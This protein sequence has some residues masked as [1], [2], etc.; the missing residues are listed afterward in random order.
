MPA[1][2][3]EFTDDEAAQVLAEGRG[4]AAAMLDLAWTLE[5]KLPGTRAAFAGG[6]L[7]HS[8]AQVIAL[9][10]AFL[11]AAEARAAEAEVL[12]RAGRLTPGGLRA[13]IARAVMAVAP[14]KA[15]KRREAAARDAR[16]AAVGRGLRERR[17]GRAGTPPGAGAGRR[18]AD[19]L[20]GPAA[21]ES[22]AGRGHGPAAR[23][24]LPRPAARPGL[25]PRRPGRDAARRAGWTAAAAPAAAARDRRQ[26]G[27]RQQDGYRRQPGT[28]AG[29]AGIPAGAPAPAPPGAGTRP[30][31]FAGRLHLTVP[32]ATLL[33]LA[34]RPGEI[35]GLGPA[36]PW[37]ARDLTRA[38]ARNPATTWCVTVTDAHGH[39]IGH[40][41]A[42]P[43]TPHRPAPAAGNPARRA[44]MTRPAGPAPA[45]ARVRLH[46]FWPGRATGRLRILAAADRSRATGP[47]HRARPD[48]DRYLRPP[49]PGRR[50]RPRQKTPAPVPDPARHMHR[51]HLPQTVRA[52]R[53]R[54]QHPLRS[55]RP[56]VPL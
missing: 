13:A 2:R 36:D 54:A 27:Y 38:A 51:P 10:V 11:D 55:R 20:V 25:P 39:A 35:P 21:P 17:A 32:L 24:R 7:R 49:V 34:D 16:V 40:G 41:C 42:R 29:Q 8:K 43:R 9:A 23:P 53:L 56:V 1:E 46:A 15:R 31:G 48:R 18:P 4:A 5:V 52:G 50:A 30:A 33:E 3:E 45:R 22:R 44:G 28:A 26:H 37:L 47:D 14:A 12:G 6:R 19:Q